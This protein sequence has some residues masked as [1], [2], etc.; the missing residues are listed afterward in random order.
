MEEFE[1]WKLFHLSSG[2]PLLDERAKFM[3]V[4]SERKTSVMWKTI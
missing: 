2:V 4:I 1:K 3:Q